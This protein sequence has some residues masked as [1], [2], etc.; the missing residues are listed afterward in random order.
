MLEDETSSLVLKWEVYMN[1]DGL[2]ER[3][4]LAMC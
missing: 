2:E 1:D 4:S 3:V